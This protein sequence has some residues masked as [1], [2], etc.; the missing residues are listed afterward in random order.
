MK[1]VLSLLLLCTLVL[2]VLP[3]GAN[4]AGTR[5]PIYVGNPAVDYMAEEILD[6]LDLEDKSDYEQ[7]VTVYD[8]IIEHGERYEW[9]GEYRFDPTE[10]QLAS[11]GSFAQDYYDRLARGEILL[12][13]DWEKVSGLCGSD[14]YGYS[15]DDTAQVASQAYSMMLKMTGSC[16]S[17]TS[18][19]TVLLGHLGYDSRQ[20]HGEF[21]NMDGTQVEH[22]WSYALIDGKWYWMDIRIDHAIG[23]GHQYFMIE[24][25]EQWAKEHIWS[26]EQ[27]DWLYEHAEEIYEL[28]EETD[29][30]PTVPSEP[31]AEPSEP[32]A[33]PAEVP[34][35]PSDDRV[36]LISSDWAADYMQ[37]A[38]EAG[39]MPDALLSKNLS[40]NM[41]RQ[42]FSSVV[43]RLYESLT[44]AVLPDYD[45]PS[46]FT[47]CADADVLNA[48][49]LGIVNGMGDGTF[50][51]DATL[52]REQAA[53]MLG[54]TYELATQGIVFD[55][56]FLPQSKDEFSDHGDIFDY[57]KPYIYFFVGNGVING[58]GDGTFAPKGTLTREQALKISVVCFE[59][60]QISLSA[61]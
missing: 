55:G 41:T 35:E 18:L 47:D 54:R 14:Y 3:V 56:A 44:G 43:V 29:P 12:R 48:F 9:D 37:R 51:P 46:P 57:A 40:H 16:A 21:V 19:L 7:I 53:A 28:Y 13:Q 11:Q 10:V 36:V 24:D 61:S 6:D 39:L 22:T 5:K 23:G 34:T 25:T 2:T 15:L 45:G 38:L 49:R 60:L 58:M 32:S 30:E 17:F 1:R 33:P 59:N 8:W 31:P 52:T 20:F 4:A 42:E 26:Q 50:A 27:S